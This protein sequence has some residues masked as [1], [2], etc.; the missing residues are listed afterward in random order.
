MN[1]VLGPVLGFRG[2]VEGRWLVGVLVV[3]EGEVAPELLWAA[4]GG[5]AAPAPVVQLAAHKGHTVWRFDLAVE[6]A[7]ADLAVR[8]EIAGR[9]W[10]FTVPAAGR[11]PRMAY[12]S[13]NGF[14]SLKLL[15]AVADKNA[16]W[17][18]LAARHATLPYHLLLQGGDQVYADEMWETV[19]PLKRWNELPAAA[20]DRAPFGAA[21]A[22]KVRDFYFNLYLRRWAQPEMAALHA[23]VPTV[24]MWDDHDIFDGWGSYPP[25]RHGCPVFQGLFTLAREH[26]RIF[27]RQEGAPVAHATALAPTAQAAALA[28]ALGFTVGH[29]IG[30]LALLVLDLRSE[31]TVDQVLSPAHWQAVYAWLDRLAGCRHLVV[32]SSIPVIYPGFAL[33]ERALCSLPRQQEIEDDLKDHWTS[34]GHRAE[35]LRL[36]H[37]LLAFSEQ[38]KTRVTLLSGDVH[39]AALGILESRRDGPGSNAAVINQLIASGIVHPGPPGVVLFALEHLFPETEEVDRGLTARMVHFPGTRCRYLGARNFLSLEPD[40]GAR[41]SGR[42]WANWFCEGETTPFTKVIHPV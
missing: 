16:L 35:R 20:A 23:T 1:I 27:Q 6:Q 18:V 14:S 24:M 17:K 30:D 26:F 5:E 36:L 2:V 38:T 9:S 15:K 33:L 25:A 8:Y 7:A 31:R 13:C 29:R 22:A 32:M 37:R 40:D 34:R 19:E 10:T 12:A 39:V 4:Q 42:L 11:P 3:T 41:D 28:P 21:L